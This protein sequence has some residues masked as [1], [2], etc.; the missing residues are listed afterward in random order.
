VPKQLNIRSDE[1]YETA[2]RLAHRLG[3]TTTEAVVKAL[4]HLDSETFKL[5][6]YED[7]TPEQKAEYEEFRALARQAR[8]E[9]KNPGFSEDD[10]YDEYGLPK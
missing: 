3:T 2:R 4:R 8:L 9:A 1:A 7:L 10:L 5:P 6:A